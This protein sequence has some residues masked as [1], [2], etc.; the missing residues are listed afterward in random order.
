M[1]AYATAPCTAHPVPEAV[2]ELPREGAQAEADAERGGELRQALA[3]IDLAA[4]GLLEAQHEAQLVQREGGQVGA[5]D[6][7]GSADDAVAPRAGGDE[8]RRRPRR[9]AAARVPAS[10]AACSPRPR[11]DRAGDLL[12]REA[13]ARAHAH[14]VAREHVRDRK[15]VATR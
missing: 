4:V 2:D 12:E 14:D 15:V 9:V 7:G 6:E 1:P 11:R 8:L 3:Q 5:G 10:G 13:F